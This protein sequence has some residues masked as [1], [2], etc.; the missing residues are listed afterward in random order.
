MT[1][2]NQEEAARARQIALLRAALASEERRR[3][4]QHG[5]KDIARTQRIAAAFRI[6][7]DYEYLLQLR[8]SGDPRWHQAGN[9]AQLAASMYEEQ[10]TAA[11]AGQPV[12]GPN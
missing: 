4:G 11:R 5:L 8:N 9:R 6:N 10:R 1:G 3:D 7:E 2:H 12:G